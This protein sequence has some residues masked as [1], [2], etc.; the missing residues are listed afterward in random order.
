MIILIASVSVLVAYFV[1]N[2]TPLGNVNEESVAVPTIDRIETE[3][4]SP[5][6]RVFN[7]DAINPQVEIQINPDNLDQHTE[8]T[9]LDISSL[10]EDDN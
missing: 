9:E 3:V 1:A 4:V 10:E 6:P 8:Y 5:D 7:E 2:A